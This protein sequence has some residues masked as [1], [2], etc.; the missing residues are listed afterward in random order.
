MMS[1]ATR[2]LELRRILSLIRIKV[3]KIIKYNFLI[4]SNAFMYN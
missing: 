1:Y 4:L 2:T 3:E